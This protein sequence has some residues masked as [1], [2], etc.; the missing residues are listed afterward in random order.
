MKN[1]LF[2]LFLASSFSITAQNEIL[3]Y[4]M[5]F[6]FD[7]EVPNMKKASFQLPFMAG[8]SGGESKEIK[9][10]SFRINEPEAKPANV[11]A[12]VIRIKGVK[13]Y[14]MAA[15]TGPNEMAFFVCPFLEDKKMFGPYTFPIDLPSVLATF[16]SP[17]GGQIEETYIHLEEK[18][19]MPGNFNF[20][21]KGEMIEMHKGYY[22]LEFVMFKT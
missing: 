4:C 13:R 1:V 19:I 8:R 21:T 10:Y 17:N 14:E 6:E 7:V 2:I 9:H 20:L 15:E 5:I 3:D 12:R 22:K 11:N 16:P 18:L